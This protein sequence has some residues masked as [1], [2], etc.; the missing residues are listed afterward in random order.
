[1]DKI[2]SL[3]KGK[4]YIHSQIK[5]LGKLEMVDA[6]VPC[7]IQFC[8]RG[9]INKSCRKNPRELCVNCGGVKSEDC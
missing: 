2:C 4:G 3:C 8:N 5:N 1:M 7:P 9:T 6:M